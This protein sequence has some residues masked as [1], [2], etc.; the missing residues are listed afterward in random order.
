ML[1]FKE[2]FIKIG[3]CARKGKKINL[4]VS[5][6]FFVINR[7]TYVLNKSYPQVRRDPAAA[8]QV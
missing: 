8:H 2:I 4:E 6:F 7:R 3:L 5:Q 1:A